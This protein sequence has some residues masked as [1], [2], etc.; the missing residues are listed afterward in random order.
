MNS[1]S[2]IKIKGSLQIEF[3]NRM[4]LKAGVANMWNWE[5]M[6]AATIVSSG[7]GPRRRCPIS[8]Q[9]CTTPDMIS[10]KP[11]EHG[12]RSRWNPVG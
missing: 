3:P 1:A 7:S 5:S 12:S 11:A 10:F 9:P 6:L 4:R 8:R 2:P